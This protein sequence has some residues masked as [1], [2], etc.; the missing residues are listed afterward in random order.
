M[1]DILSNVSGLT[2]SDFNSARVA[3]KLITSN[4]YDNSIAQ[5]VVINADFSGVNDANE[6]KQAFNNLI[7]RASQYTNGNRR[8]Y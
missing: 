5:N 7:N 2:G 6:I 1:R 4:E 8:T 3:S